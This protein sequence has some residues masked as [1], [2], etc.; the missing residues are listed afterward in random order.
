M[1]KAAEKMG[2]QLPPTEAAES[3]PQPNGRNG[4]SYAAEWR[5]VTRSVKIQAYRA[6][7]ARCDDGTCCPLSW[8]LGPGL[9][10]K[11]AAPLESITGSPICNLEA[12]ME[13]RG[14]FREIHWRLFR[15][16]FWGACSWSRPTNLLT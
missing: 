11:C 14:C 8:C 6:P 3:K 13:N 15:A 9:G 5:C 10:P 16:A 2:C 1:N 12:Q 4:S 7:S